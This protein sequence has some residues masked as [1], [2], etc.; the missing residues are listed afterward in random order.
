V[1]YS[2]PL[3]LGVEQGETPR[4]RRPSPIPYMVEGERSSDA[5][6]LRQRRLA[7][8]PIVVE[9]R[10]SGKVELLVSLTPPWS[11]VGRGGAFSTT[12]GQA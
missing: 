3:P 5:K 8:S 7:P 1:K 10:G 11:R 4:G 2:D 9:A 6:L 12:G